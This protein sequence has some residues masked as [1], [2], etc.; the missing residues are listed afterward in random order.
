MTFDLELHVLYTPYLL[1]A[2]R[3]TFNQGLPEQFSFITTFRNRNPS[4]DR[5]SLIRITNTRN[6]L[7]I[8]S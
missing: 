1:L 2:F 3:R 4:T 8:L 7:N 6:T 5:W